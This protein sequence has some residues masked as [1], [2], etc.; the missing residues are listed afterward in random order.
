MYSYW[1]LNAFNIKKINRQCQEVP[2]QWSWEFGFSNSFCSLQKPSHCFWRTWSSCL[3][4]A[5][6]R[7]KCFF[8]LI[9][10][11][12]HL[13]SD[14]SLSI[15]AERGMEKLSRSFSLLFG[16]ESR[17][18]DKCSPSRSDAG[19]PH[20]SEGGAGVKI[21]TTL[22]SHSEGLWDYVHYLV[23]SYQLI[24]DRWRNVNEN[25]PGKEMMKLKMILN[26]FSPVFTV[27]ATSQIT[28]SKAVSSTSIKFVWSNVTGADSYILFLA[29]TMTS[30]ARVYNQTY[31]TT[32]G[33]VNGLTPSTTYACYVYSSNSAGRGAKS[34]I[35]T[36]LTCKCM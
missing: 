13:D 5:Q 2:V 28:F 16:L 9:F 35:K 19:S 29:E 1:K 3:P 7:M 34:N 23:H 14:V 21:G 6:K 24:H 31:T 32:S 17:E 33:Q 25:W 27:P 12:Y 18:L 8:V 30:T 26:F 4:C 15:Y 22:P 11:M 36:I 20:Y 10:R